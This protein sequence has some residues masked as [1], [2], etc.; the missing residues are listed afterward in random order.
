ML[1][2]ILSSLGTIEKK[3]WCSEKNQKHYVDTG[4]NKVFVSAVI[5]VQCYSNYVISDT[6]VSGQVK[7]SSV[8]K[9]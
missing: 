8:K 4:P 3:S 1:L 2:H 5:A 7:M 6:F 9:V